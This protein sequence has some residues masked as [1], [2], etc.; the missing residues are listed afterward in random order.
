MDDTLSK[1]YISTEAIRC[2]HV[3]LLCVQDQASDRPC[4]ADVV[5]ML[6]NETDRPQPKQPIFTFQRSPK[7]DPQS[8]NKSKFSLNEAT[9]SLIEGR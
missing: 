1:S 6:S 9:I 7:N 2:I 4:M 3:A 5:F 8:H